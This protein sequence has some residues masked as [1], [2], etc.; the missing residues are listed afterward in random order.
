M[1]AFEG[2]AACAGAG[3]IVRLDCAAGAQPLPLQGG[4]AV[5]SLVACRWAPRR[6]RRSVAR[7]C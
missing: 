5:K 6:H 7:L 1:N 2:A 3:E 4:E